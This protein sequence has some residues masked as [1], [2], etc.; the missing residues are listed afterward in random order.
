[1]GNPILLDRAM[2]D[3]SPRPN[4]NFD[5]QILQQYQESLKGQTDSRTMY[6]LNKSVSNVTKFVE[7]SETEGTKSD[8]ISCQK[9]TPKNGIVDDDANNQSTECHNIMSGDSPSPKSSDKA[10]TIESDKIG[11]F[12]L[13]VNQDN[14]FL[15]V[16]DSEI[17]TRKGNL[18]EQ[19]RQKSM[20]KKCKAKGKKARSRYHYEVNNQDLSQRKDVVNKTLLRSLKRYYTSVFPFEIIKY[21]KSH[22]PEIVTY[23]NHNKKPMT[24][25]SVKTLIEIVRASTNARPNLK[26]KYEQAMCDDFHA[27]LYKYSHTKLYGLFKLPQVKFL[28]KDYI[29]NGLEVMLTNDETLQKN[30][31]V[32]RSA[33]ARFLDIINS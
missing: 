24:I 14:T 20:R 33:G 12:G 28:V 17:I 8:E 23:V 30:P 29:E 21:L 22:K 7:S 9:A 2:F 13:R 3:P 5:K 11:E 31:G 18:N 16:K 10:H 32:Y 27:C 6:N 4:P 19:K 25:G 1:M 15:T 26:T